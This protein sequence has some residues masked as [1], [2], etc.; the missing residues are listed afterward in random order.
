M[1][2]SSKFW[3]RIAARYARKPVADE[4]AYRRKLAV[5]RD[6]LA[7][8]MDVLEFGCGTGSTAIVLSH[9]FGTDQTVWDRMMPALEARFQVV[10]YDLAC[11]GSVPP[12]I[13]DHARYGALDAYAEDLVEILRRLRLRRVGFIGHSVSGMIGMLAARRHPERF[14]RMVMIAPSPCYLD[15]PGYEGGFTREQIDALLAA[16]GDNYQAWAR[17]FAPIMVRGVEGDPAV[18][19]FAAT[20]TAMRPDIALSAAL[21]IF[22]SD[23]RDRLDG[24]DLP[25]LILQTADDPAVP[26]SVAR[27]LHDR[28]PNSR[29]T[30]VDSQ[31]HLPHLTD[32][33]KVLDAILAFLS[34]LRRLARLRVATG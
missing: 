19:E 2:P 16:L 23:L 10:R 14:S 17:S 34:D 7:P 18:E 4:A 29:L 11:A 9:G 20:M 27:F 28:W 32:H 13:F 26:A 3:D 31:G 6:Y 25:T 15:H 30:V 24:F 22:G 21:T 12:E 1:P 5:T 33:A 8:D